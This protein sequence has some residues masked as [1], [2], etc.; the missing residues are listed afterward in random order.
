VTLDGNKTSS[1]MTVFGG[2]SVTGYTFTAAGNV[3]L[4]SVDHRATL[5]LGADAVLAMGANTLNV[6]NVDIVADTTAGH[7]AQI[8]GA[9]AV[10]FYGLISTSTLTIADS[11]HAHV[12]DNLT[13]VQVVPGSQ[14][15]TI[16][17]STHAHT[18]D[19]L[20]LTSQGIVDIAEEI[21][22]TSVYDVG[23]QVRLIG[24]WTDPNNSYAVVDP[25]AVNC[26][27]LAPSGTLTTY[28]YGVDADLKKESTGIYYLDLDIDESGDWCYRWFSTGTA[29]AAEEN[30]FT[31]RNQL[32]TSTRSTTWTAQ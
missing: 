28:V 29:Q 1:T 32:V 25:T 13:L 20:T 8:T 10:A 30:K 12:S 31:V 3:T 27:I 16:P 18:S 11:V 7:E 6:A 21:G 23:D 9:G 15:L 5:T 24:K 17:D 19:N 4:G 2:L 26:S 14:T 22:T